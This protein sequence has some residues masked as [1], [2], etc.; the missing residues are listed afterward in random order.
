VKEITIDGKDYY[1]IPKAQRLFN[2]GRTI[3]IT[4]VQP[5]YHLNCSTLFLGLQHPKIAEVPNQKFNPNEI[6]QIV[7]IS[8]GE[9]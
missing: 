6:I 1:L 8:K 2:A 5:K 7:N 4:S 3:R 9:V